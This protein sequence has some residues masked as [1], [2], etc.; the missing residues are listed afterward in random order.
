VL[1]GFKKQLLF[2]LAVVTLQ[3]SVISY[4]P[5]GPEAIYKS[6]EVAPENDLVMVS[7]GCKA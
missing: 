7:P 2:E 5:A 4:S 1:L 6:M 3:E